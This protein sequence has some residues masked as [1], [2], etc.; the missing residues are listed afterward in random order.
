MP[1]YISKAT[2][3]SS[4]PRAPDAIARAPLLNKFVVRPARGGRPRTPSS[5]AASA[6]DSGRAADD[7]AETQ[8]SL[9]DMRQF[10]DM[11]LNDFNLSMMPSTTYSATSS[12]TTTSRRRSRRR[13]R[14]RR[15][16]RLP[17]ARRVG[18]R[19]SR[20]PETTS[21]TGRSRTTARSAW[22]GMT[23]RR[24]SGRRRRAGTASTAGAWTSGSRPRTPPAPCAAA[25]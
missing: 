10:M 16:Q 4:Q 21:T 9:L 11:T 13:P 5:T 23:R 20:R 14:R 6:M 1:P 18:R 2:H 24:R 22:T 3:H 12:T 8:E 19:S 17:P 25:T 15:R 7:A